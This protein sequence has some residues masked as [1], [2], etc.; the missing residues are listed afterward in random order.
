M[1][2]V[3]ASGNTVTFTLKAADSTWPYV[4]TTGAG[5]IVDSKVFPADKL[6]RRQQ[7]HRLRPVRA[8]EV[9]AEPGRGVHAQPALRRQRQARELASSSSTTSRTRRRSSPTSQSGAVDLAYRDLDPTQLQTLSRPERHHASC[10]ARASRSATWSSTRSS[11]PAPPTPQKLA[12]RKAAAQV[13]DRST[14]RLATSTSGTVKPLYS[15][16]PQG[17]NGATTAFQTAYGASPNVDDGQVDAGRRWCHDAGQLTLWY[18]VNHYNDDDLATELQR[19]LNA[20]GLFNVKLQTAEWATYNKAALADEYQTYLFGWFP[21]YP[22]A[23][24]YTGPFLPCKTAFL[25]DHFCNPKVDTADQ[26]P[27]RP[28]PTHSARLPD[29]ATDPDP[30]WRTDVPVI[31]IWQGGQVAA[32]RSGVTGVQSTLDPSYTFRFWLVGK[33]S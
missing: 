14:H 9:H 5:A 29:F 4:L 25:N 23:D 32:V 3:T 28:R 16:V 30:H 20:A 33:S 13:V 11:S 10:R 12:I 22:D 26:R 6:H 27:R 19:E 31:P 17:L 21:D 2:S 8:D 24:D 18:N 1:K 15:I 7:D